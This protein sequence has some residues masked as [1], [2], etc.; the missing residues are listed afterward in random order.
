MNAQ[1]VF[2]DSDNLFAKAIK[3][4]TWSDWSH[5]GIM[6]GGDLVDSRYK[7]GGVT[8]TDYL[9]R[10]SQ[11]KRIQILE[12]PIPAAKVWPYVTSQIGKPYDVSA[13]LG[14]PFRRDWQEDDKW[15]C[16]ELVAWA[17]GAAGHPLIYKQHGRVTPQDLYEAARVRQL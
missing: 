15:F 6:F 17:F 7:D 2:M 11:Y 8:L 4:V 1:I 16:S 14:I 12:V 5:V 10:V 9:T 13:V 3:A